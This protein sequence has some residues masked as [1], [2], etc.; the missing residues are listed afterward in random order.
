MSANDYSAELEA[1]A[2]AARRTG[3]FRAIGDVYDILRVTPLGI[4]ATHA[5]DFIRE[6]MEK[7]EYTPSPATQEGA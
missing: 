4:P 5:V 7:L 3:Y 2:V 1:L 6:E